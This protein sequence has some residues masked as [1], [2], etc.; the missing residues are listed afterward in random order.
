MVKQVPK[1]DRIN[2][3]IAKAY[4]DPA[5]DTSEM[6]VFEAIVANTKPLRRTTGLHAK[7]VLGTDVLAELTQIVNSGE[8]VPLQAMHQ[9]GLPKGKVFYAEMRQGEDGTPQT[10]MLFYLPKTNSDI[11]AKIDAGVIGEVSVGFM[12]KKLL[13][14]SCGFDYMSD[15]ATFENL[16]D[17]T[18]ANGH[19][20]GKDGVHARVHGVEKLSELSLVDRG[21]VNGAVILPRPK[22]TPDSPLTA[23]FSERGMDVRAFY[24]AAS[25]E[26][27]PTNPETN[28]MELAE[29][30]AD[31]IVAT[32][33]LTAAKETISSKDAEIA[34]LKAKLATSEGIVATLK[35]LDGTKAKAD[36]DVALSLLDEIGRATYAAMGKP[37][38]KLPETI[39]ERVASIKLARAELALAIPEGGRAHAAAQTN[40]KS[41]QAPSFS[42]FKTKE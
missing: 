31:L 36:L 22:Q 32:R 39:S 38:T 9:G 3:L 14:S 34:E 11:T 6:A 7:A 24:I 41:A 10:H 23:R 21:A 5:V 16:W 8:H 28:T 15:E 17:C 19:A 30:K 20:I 1:S 40:T 27:P 33:D 42:A 12:P 37:D 29:V 35:E 26:N 13:C 4:G 2:A 25:A 18:C